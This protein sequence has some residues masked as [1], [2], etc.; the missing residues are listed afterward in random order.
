MAKSHLL[1]GLENSFKKLNRKL[2]MSTFISPSKAYISGVTLGTPA[3]ALY[4]YKN[5]DNYG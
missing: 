4:T 2:K 3:Y 1:I 5:V